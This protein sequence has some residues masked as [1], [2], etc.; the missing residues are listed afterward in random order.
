MKKVAVAVLSFGLLLLPALS[1]VHVHIHNL[2]GPTNMLILG[3]GL[4]A[5]A[6][7]GRK[8]LQEFNSNEEKTIIK[9]RQ[10]TRTI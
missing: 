5:L 10:E 8:Q 9:Q 2:S 1:W 6:G 7:I 3:F 4:L